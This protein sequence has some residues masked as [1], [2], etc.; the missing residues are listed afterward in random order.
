MKVPKSDDRPKRRGTKRNRHN[1]A[2]EPDHVTEM[3]KLCLQRICELQADL[4][5]EEEM[6]DPEAAGYTA[7]AM[8]TLQFLSAHGL[9]PDHPMVRSLKER[10]LRNRE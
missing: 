2:A 3:L 7:C 8:E 4:E 6:P 10:L 9:P 5:N 1:R